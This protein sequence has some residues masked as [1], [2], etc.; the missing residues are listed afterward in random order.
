MAKEDVRAK[1]KV[2]DALVDLLTEAKVPMAS[3]EDTQAALLLMIRDRLTS[4][5]VITIVANARDG[6]LQA[7]THNVRVDSSEALTH[8]ANISIAV[9][10]QFQQEAHKWQV[11]E[12]ATRQINASNGQTLPSGPAQKPDL[13]SPAS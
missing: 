2:L 12:E 10:D 13:A 1:A 3:L 7:I 11:K 5:V 4:P 8:L 6:T 9:A